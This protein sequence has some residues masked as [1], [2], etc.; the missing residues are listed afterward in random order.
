MKGHRVRLFEK[1]KFPREH[2]GESLLPF[3]YGIFDELGV[4]DQLK[5][6]FVRKPGV[7]FI[8][9]DG[10]SYTTWCF[11]HVIKDPSYL[12]FHV[13]R[14][15]LD[16]ILLENARKHGVTVEES[17]L[18]R[19]V[20]L[21]GRDQ[22]V[23]VTVSTSSGQEATHRAKFLVDASGRDT[24]LASRNRWK[25]PHKTLDRTALSTHWAGGKY[26][27]GI[28]EGLLQIVYLGGDKKGW[29]WVIPV[30]TD[31]LSVGIVLNHSYIRKRKAELAA[32]GEKDWQVVL[33]REE[34]SSSPFVKDILAKANMI[35][36][37][38]I[39]GNYSYLVE[40]KYGSNFCLV[41]D[42]GSF[43][44][45]IFASGVYLSLQSSKVAAE[46][47]DKIFAS[48]DANNHLEE[49]YD[50]ING[51]YALVDRAIG[52]FYNPGALNFAQIGSARDIM[53]KQH[54]T[55]LAV[56]HYLLAGDFFSNHQKYYEFLDLLEDPG[57]L[58][59]YK[60]L[61]IDREEFQSSS[62]GLSRVEIFHNLLQE[63][64]NQAEVSAS[65]DR[66]RKLPK[67]A[68]PH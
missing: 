30:G 60:T 12:S 51:A 6:R 56:G 64:A 62:C 5:E 23:E 16:Q 2:V 47:I 25:V 18:V 54:E 63:T 24:F 46:A 52:L 49:A 8:D 26:I 59:K 4:L 68:V 66:E 61:V 43:I 10:S 13:L 1:E 34:L 33:Y 58:R 41:G 55:A 3:C 27:E 19:D 53:H 28:E 65:A 31:R 37:L 15:Q 39:N 35:Q 32:G 29:I 7:R 45:P 42:S 9:I 11:G 22:L 36:P 14:D 40:K 44:D 21:E 17:T 67:P 48:G 50:Q 57:L 20:N 38:M